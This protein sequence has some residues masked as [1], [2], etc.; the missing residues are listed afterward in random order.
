MCEC[1]VRLDVFLRIGHGSSLIFRNIVLKVS[2][3]SV[4][5][6]IIGRRVLESLGC[7][8]REML[9]AARV[10]DGG[11]I[12]VTERLSQDGNKDMSGKIAALFGELVFHNGEC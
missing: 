11:D 12:D 6:P 1:E 3:E 2:N 9:M 10:K 4:Q 8:S 7:D 5:T